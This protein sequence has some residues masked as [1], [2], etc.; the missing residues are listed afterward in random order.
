M[1]IAIIG[2]GNVAHFFALRLK[3]AGIKPLQ[4]LS[5]NAD[6]ARAL[7]EKVESSYATNLEELDTRA[8]MYLLAVKDDVLRNLPATECWREK[9]LIHTAGSVS[10][11][12]LERLSERVACIWPL[13]SLS[14]ELLPTHREIPLVINCKVEQDLH[15]VKALAQTLSDRLYFLDD[16]QKT[17][18]HLAAVFANNFSNH[19]FALARRIAEEHG[20]PFDLLLPLI[21]HTVAKLHSA[22][23]EQNQT[24]PAIRHDEQTMEAHLQLLQQDPLRAAL[25]RMMSNSI[26]TL[27]DETRNDS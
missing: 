20:I 10:L 5:P 18:A 17:Q 13:Y 15:L 24:G 22:T 9:L 1:N 2:S 7:A 6:H 12:D 26:Q 4:I 14:K 23:P 21:D 16:A 19:L 11:S 25:Y 8:D 3:A 27:H